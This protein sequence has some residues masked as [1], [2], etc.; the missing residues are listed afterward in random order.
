[1]K[2]L[3]LSVLLLTFLSATYSQIII[4]SVDVEK[5]LGVALTSTTYTSSDTS[6]LGVVLGASGSNK[7]WNL[8]GRSFTMSETRTSTLLNKAASGAPSQS[9]SAFSSANY[10]TRR[11]ST[12]KPQ[13][14]DW[15]YLSVTST[16][17]SYCGYASDSSGILKS[18]QTNVPAQRS[19]N[20]PT[21]Y[22]GSWTWSSTVTSS[23][24]GPGGSVGAGVGMSGSDVVDGYG[25]VITPEGSFSALRM[26]RRTDMLFGFFTLSSYRYDFIDQNRSIAS[27]DAGSSGVSASGVTYYRQGSGTQVD[28]ATMLPDRTTL[29]QNFP[30]PFNPTTT[31]SYQLSAVSDVKLEVVDGLGR[32]VAEFN[33][34]IQQSGTYAFRWDAS[35]LPSGIY[36]C[37]LQASGSVQVR[38]L[39]LMR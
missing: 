12:S 19:Q 35:G 8:T 20:F 7:T 32:S 37:R 9:T 5:T 36:F 4:S 34:G 13:F 16:A 23:T 17:L 14:T 27:I 29:F 6:G 30:N 1:M 31:I 3:L 39:I 15:T 33:R 2:P 24:Y 25:T 10:V 21:T 38:K 11:T 28:H 22:P 26:K 18:L